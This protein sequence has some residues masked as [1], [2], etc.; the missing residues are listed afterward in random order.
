MMQRH[1][2]CFYRFI[3]LCGPVEWCALINASI[4]RL[5]V[6]GKSPVTVSFIAAIALPYSTAC[7]MEQ[8]ERNHLNVLIRLFG[9]E[10]IGSRIVE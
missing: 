7:C 1:F 6:Q 8:P 2:T 9:I 4:S 5:L 10:Y 3:S